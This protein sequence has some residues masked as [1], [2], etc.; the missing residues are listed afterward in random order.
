MGAHTVWIGPKGFEVKVTDP[1]GH[2]TVGSEFSEWENAL[3]RSNAAERPG[4]KVTDQPPRIRVRPI[5]VRLLGILGLC[6][7]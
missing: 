3:A 1:E 4:Q 2:E 6:N 5:L 7:W